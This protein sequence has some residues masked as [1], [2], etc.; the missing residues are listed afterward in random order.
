MQLFAIFT[1]PITLDPYPKV[2]LFPILGTPESLT[3]IHTFPK[4]E[5]FLPILASLLTVTGAT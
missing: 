5:Q 2:Q 4:I 3:P 1:P